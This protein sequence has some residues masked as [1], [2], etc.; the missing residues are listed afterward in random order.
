M[1]DQTVKTTIHDFGAVPT[2]MQ[3][4]VDR[5]LL[6]G[7]CWAV[8]Q[9]RDLVDVNCAGWADREAKTALTT[10]HLFRAF[11]NTKLPTSCAV[12]LLFEAG[13][14]T[15]DDPIERHAWPARTGGFRRVKIWRRS[16]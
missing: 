16:S 15:L 5:D 13:K 3:S 12:M 1:H 10:D 14:L 8:L 11:S 2:A 6:S 7:V 9:G 4:Y